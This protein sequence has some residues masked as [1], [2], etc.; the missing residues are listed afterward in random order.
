[1]I[2]VYDMLAKVLYD[3]ERNVEYAPWTCMNDQG[4]ASR[5]VIAGQE[6]VVYAIKASLEL[7]SRIAVS[8]R[9]TM[10]NR[11]IEFLIG[12]NEGVEE[13]PKFR[14][15]YSM[16]SV[17]EQV[18]YYE[19]PYRET[20]AMINEMIALEYSI[21]PQTGAI[22]IEEKGF[23]RKDRYTSLSYGNYFAELLEKDLFADS[24][25]YEF[26]TFFN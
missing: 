18:A 13:I 22:K 10:E 2:S 17:E 9:A 11:M 24:G 12:P 6:P 15:E 19:R 5:I 16:A 14:P 3:E 23:A 4:L 26:M 7:N 21:M 1:M 25:E 8:M 20:E